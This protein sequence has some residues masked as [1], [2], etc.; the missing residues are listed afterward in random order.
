MMQIFAH[1]GSSGTHPENTL[2]AFAEAVRLGADGIELDVQMTKDQQLIVMHDEEV[3]RTTDGK[4]AIKDETLAEIKKLNAGSWFDEKYSSTKVPTL[5]E[6]LD[7]LVA[8]NFRG[9]LAIELKTDK[10]AYPGIEEKISALMTSQTW[11]FIYWYSSFNLQ[12]LERIHA[13]E[14]DTRIDFTMGKSEKKPPLALA[15]DF[16]QGIHPSDEWVWQ[17]A[18]QIRTFPLAV[19]PWT[20]NEETKV[21]SCLDCGVTGIFTD[22]PE[23]ALAVKKN[24]RRNA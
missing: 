14:P 8:R 15:R 2:P 22:F 16:V 5:K 7:L 19:R 23:M 24:Y 1:R 9:I 12:S 13:L 18:E 4:G 21:K 6:V 20:I 3:D 10:E 17:H 11:P